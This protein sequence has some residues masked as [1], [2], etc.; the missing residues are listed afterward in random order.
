MVSTYY[1]VILCFLLLLLVCVCVCV[2]LFF[3]CVCVCVFNAILYAYD[4]YKYT[5]IISYEH[6]CEP[7]VFF[8]SFIFFCEIFFFPV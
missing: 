3:V 4:G 5:M 6:Q 7:I 1:W 2:V 8:S